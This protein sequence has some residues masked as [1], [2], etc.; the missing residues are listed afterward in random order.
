MPIRTIT[1]W[2]PVPYVSGFKDDGRKPWHARYLEVH[3][4]GIERTMFRNDLLSDRYNQAVAIEL[5]Y[6]QMGLVVFF[7]MN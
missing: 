5:M 7:S 6:K 4:M 1:S 2:H 3:V